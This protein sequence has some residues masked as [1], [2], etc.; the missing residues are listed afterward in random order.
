MADIHSLI[1]DPEKVLTLVREF[2]DTYEIRC[3]ES[4]HQND[5][6]IENAYDLLEELGEAAGWA[7]PEEDEDEDITGF[8]YDEDNPF[9]YED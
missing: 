8:D 6:V 9:E 4:V 3:A 1:K 5:R 7:E 2:I